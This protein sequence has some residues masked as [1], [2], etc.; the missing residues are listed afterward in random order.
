MKEGFKS[1]LENAFLCRIFLLV[2]EQQQSHSMNAV[3]GRVVNFFG[4]LLSLHQMEC[5][6]KLR[7]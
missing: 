7:K 1:R 2:S 4:R 6:L 3:Y 5:G